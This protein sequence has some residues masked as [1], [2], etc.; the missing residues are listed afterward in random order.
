MALAI[1]ASNSYV[2]PDP[3]HLPFITPAG[4][5]L[6]EAD[7][8]TQLYFHDHTFALKRQYLAKK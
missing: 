8:I 6:P 2:S 3:D 4:V 5:L 7:D 1:K